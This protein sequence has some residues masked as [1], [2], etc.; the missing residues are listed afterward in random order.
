MR[1]VIRDASGS[2]SKETCSAWAREL[3]ALLVRAPAGSLQ[4][5]A[6][7]VCEVTTAGGHYGEETYTRCDLVVE[8]L[9]DGGW[10]RFED[11][12]AGS[13]VAAPPERMP[14]TDDVKA[15]LLLARMA[16]LSGGD[17][18]APTRDEEAVDA[19][20]TV[21]AGLS[22]PSE[23]RDG[24]EKS[25]PGLTPRLDTPENRAF[26]EF[27]R[28]TAREVRDARPSWAAPPEAPPPQTTSGVSRRVLDT[29]PQSVKVNNPHPD[30]TSALG[31]VPPGPGAAE[32]TDLKEKTRLA[33]MWLENVRR[34]GDGRSLAIRFLATDVIALVAE[35]ERLR[36]L[37]PAEA[38]RP[39]EGQ[40]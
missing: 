20:D 28:K 36:A 11:L 19:I 27:V 6:I 12:P 22:A 29:A 38:R 39:Q 9:K 2:I 30:S 35:V 34:D 14:M 33:E 10:V 7:Y 5:Y 24:V 25:Q 16:L 17:E 32:M 18:S 37:P 40:P 3:D 15:A 8:P 23:A 4:R 26:W 31:A 21:L 1:D 13:P